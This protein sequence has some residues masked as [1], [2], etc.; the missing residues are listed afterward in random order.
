MVAALY[1][2]TADEIDSGMFEQ[3]ELMGVSKWLMFI[4]SFFWDFVI[5][6]CAVIL[7]ICLTTPTSD[8]FRD[9]IKAWTSVSFSFLLSF[10]TVGSY[11]DY[12]RLNTVVIA[13]IFVVIAFVQIVAPL[14][15]ED[16]WPKVLDIRSDVFDPFEEDTGVGKGTAWIFRMIY[17]FVPPTQYLLTQIL[18]SLDS[19]GSLDIKDRSFTQHWC[20]VFLYSSLLWLI[21]FILSQ[22]NWSKDPEIESLKVDKKDLKLRP[23]SMNA[24]ADTMSKVFRDARG[25]PLIAVNRISFVVKEGRCMGVLGKNGAGKSTMMN[26]LSTLFE[27]TQGKGV[28]RYRDCVQD[29]MEIRQISGICNQKNIYWKA[30]TVREHLTFFGQLRGVP[31]ADIADL[32]HDFAMELKFIEHMDTKMD[33]LSGGNK[34]K[35]AL[36]TSVMG[37]SDVLYLDEPSAGVD[38][39]ARDEMKNVLVKLKDGRTVLFTSHTMEEAEIMC[40]DV[41]IMVKGVVEAAGEVND[42]I[43]EQSKGYFLQIDTS[44]LTEDQKSKVIGIVKNLGSVTEQP[45]QKAEIIY[46]VD[47]TVPL[48]DVFTM[49]ASLKEDFGCECIVESANL[50]QL[51]KHVV[52]EEEENLTAGAATTG[53]SNNSVVPVGTSDLSLVEARSQSEVLKLNSKCCQRCGLT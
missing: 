9:T 52:R 1:K 46:S 17:Y 27:P 36:C 28:I 43:Q 53:T 15:D 31:K 40:D 8:N 5:S 44:G 7:Y 21:L 42:L 41:V 12:E 23:N 39:F 18:F 37:A 49:T 33:Q 6:L 11:M 2:Y 30:F 32:I 26:M 10:Y 13:V 3:Q 51:F 50:A 47:F 19:S 45:A 38:P 20:L 16:L 34:R 48:S 24:T 29:K 4:V 35:V 14:I 22:Q 25:D